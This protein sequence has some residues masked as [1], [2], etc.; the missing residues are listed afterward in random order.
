MFKNLKNL[1]LLISL[2]AISAIL[3]T[4][5]LW[6]AGIR[7]LSLVLVFLGIVAVITITVRRDFL[8]YQHD[9]ATAA[10]LVRNILLDIL[11]ILITM[12]VVTL[13]AVA[14]GAMV[15]RFVGNAWGGTPGI[16][17]ALAASLLVG[18]AVGLL[19]R[20]IWRILTVR[21]RTG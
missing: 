10:G 20:W 3:A 7:L 14:V 13:A 19:V 8:D 12:V 11:G 2:F 18:W 6:P 1:G 4:T 15:A 21:P 17:A 16:V 9:K 5:L